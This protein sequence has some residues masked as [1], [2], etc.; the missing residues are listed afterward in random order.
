MQ[1]STGFPGRGPAPGRG[2]G[3]AFGVNDS[4][5]VA[6]F[7]PLVGRKV[8]TRWPEDNSFYEAVITDYN[9]VEVCLN[10][11]YTI[12]KCW[13]GLNL[14]WHFKHF[15]GRHALVYDINTADET[16][17]W[18]NLK[19]VNDSVVLE[20]FDIFDSTGM[21]NIWGF[22]LGMPLSFSTSPCTSFDGFLI[23]IF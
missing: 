22:D 15:Q 11:Y 5:E 16:W 1:Y 19:E 10:V 20:I 17:E 6:N 12:F 14:I 23:L 7:D 3:G 2:S 13:T 9:P 8:W 21:L 18:V 4:A